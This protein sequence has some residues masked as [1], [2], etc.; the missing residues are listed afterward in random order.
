[1][2]QM[3]VPELYPNYGGESSHPQQPQDQQQRTIY[4]G[5]PQEFDQFHHHNYLIYNNANAPYIGAPPVPP[6]AESA[7]A[8][9][10]VPPK[11]QP[12]QQQ[13]PIFQFHLGKGSGLE[14]YSKN[15]PAGGSSGIIG[16]TKNENSQT[17]K[18]IS[19]QQT[20]VL[21]AGYQRCAKPDKEYR[22]EL[23]EK[24]G[25]PPRTIQIWFQNRRAKA[26]SQ[27]KNNE[28]NRAA[29]QAPIAFSNYN[30]NQQYT[31]NPPPPP[32]QQSHRRFSHQGNLF[33]IQNQH[34]PPGQITSQVIQVPSTFINGQSSA[35]STSTPD[36][37]PLGTAPAAQQ[38][39]VSNYP[40]H[41]HQHHYPGGGLYIHSAPPIAPPQPP[42]VGF[43]GF[44]P[45]PTT[46]TTM[47]SLPSD[48]ELTDDAPLLTPLSSLQSPSAS[49]Y[50]GTLREK[51]TPTMDMVPE[52]APMS[53]FSITGEGSTKRRKSAHFGPIPTSA[54]EALFPS[55]SPCPS[56]QT[57]F[58]SQANTMHLPP[59]SD[60]S[61]QAAAV[62]AA[63]S[64]R[65]SVSASGAMY[66]SRRYGPG[67]RMVRHNSS[68]APLTTPVVYEDKDPT[69]PEE[70][71][72]TDYSALYTLDSDQLDGSSF[73]DQKLTFE[74]MLFMDE[75]NNNL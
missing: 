46:D 15:D 60:E 47:A 31:L 4:Q 10:P 64:L 62:A 50:V 41:H 66:N 39:P 12:P 21:E 40:E 24:T 70:T 43:T 54:T 48:S 32:H 7:T 71:N 55:S 44:Q 17:R 19:A 1:M 29:A 28:A 67:S 61:A 75:T 14:A 30:F 11:S 53:S 6:A 52:P 42:V 2:A 22:E 37:L 38:Q 59:S 18:R 16:L 35:T 26:K 63:A 65:R 36:S 56:P 20:S 9:A 5:Q 49:P 73:D 27:Q 57:S 74:Q 3:D 25:L 33:Q 34:I 23:A 72:P 8:L 45:S 51:R 58:R 13:K 69:L 68:N